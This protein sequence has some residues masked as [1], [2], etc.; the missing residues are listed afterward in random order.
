MH[1]GI[2]D[3]CIVELCNRSIAMCTRL[4]H[5]QFCCNYDNSCYCIHSLYWSILLRTTSGVLKKYYHKKTL[6]NMGESFFWKEYNFLAISCVT[7]IAYITI[8]G[9]LHTYPPVCLPYWNIWDFCFQ[10][11]SKNMIST[12]IC[13]PSCCMSTELHRRADGLVGSVLRSAY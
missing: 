1:S 11:T 13:Q 3:W 5:T 12:Q 8:K 10:Q 2:W 9:K 7:D 4:C 6:K